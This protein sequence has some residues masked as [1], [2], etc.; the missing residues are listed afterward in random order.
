MDPLRVWNLEHLLRGHG[1]EELRL[2]PQIVMDVIYMTST[3]ARPSRKLLL[4]HS[5]AISGVA[6][7][8]TRN[9]SESARIL[10]R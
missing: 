5:L 4:I 3:E 2:S 8:R 6:S 1:K 10:Y 9:G 7:F